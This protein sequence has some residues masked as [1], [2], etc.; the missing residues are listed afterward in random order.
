[1]SLISF[2][3][4]VLLVLHLLID[5]GI[6][7]HTEGET[8]IIMGLSVCSISDLLVL[9]LAHYGN[10]NCSEL[11]KKTLTGFTSITSVHMFLGRD[12]VSALPP[13][14]GLTGCDISG[15]FSDKSVSFLAK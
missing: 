12:A 13:F 6:T 10:I 8:A 5:T 1:M 2:L 4:T 11:F 15:K 14:H 7:N 9:H 3:E